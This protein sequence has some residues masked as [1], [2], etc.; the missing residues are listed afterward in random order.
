MDLDLSAFHFLRPLWLL[1]L[2]PAALLWAGW[3]ALRARPQHSGIAPQLLPYLLLQS[4]GSRGPRPIDVLAALL[5]LGAVAAAGPTWQRDEPGYLDNVAPL[6]LAV[7][8]SASMDTADVPPSRLEAV[9]RS[10]RDIAAQRKGAKTGLVVYAGTSHL[11]LPPTDDAA[12]LDLFAQALATDLLPAR[13]RD[14]A[15]A[16]ALSN[17][18]LRAERAG[19]SVLLLTDGADPANLDAVGKA[20]RA[21]PDLQVL[22]M[23]VGINGLDTGA[24]RDLAQAA[25]APLGS[26]TRSADDLDW[27]RLH[28]QQHFRAVQDAATAQPHWRDAGYWLCWPLALL[29]LMALRRGWRVSWSA[30][31]LV[32]GIWTAPQPVQAGAWADA[33]LTPDQQGRWAFDHGDYAA[34]A[35]HF[36]DPYWK[37]RAAYEAGDYAAA[38]TAFSALDTPQAHFYVGNCQTR[39]RQ[40]DAALAAY[41]KALAL[42]PEWPD[43]IFNRDI[44]RRLLAAMTQEDQ[45]DQAEPPDQSR[46]DRA[47]KDARMKTAAAPKAVSEDVWLRNLTLSPA[48]FLRGKFA[49]EDSMREATP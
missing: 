47:A 14:V 45:G 11:V 42:R 17:Q 39:L 7:D 24:L 43:A 27:V 3:R 25:H 38:L 30:C 49:V 6:V 2:V 34:A 10:V 48:Q 21:A 36:A 41:D 44:L 16:I 4:A 23:A 22:V 9:K 46:Q 33:F 13:G 29:A 18:V 35:A 5:A 12:L 32:A 31:L 8:L 1:G 20:A 37:G 26:L 40:Y 28:A 15:G 19:G